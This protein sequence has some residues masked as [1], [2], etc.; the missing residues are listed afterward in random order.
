MPLVLFYF[1]GGLLRA[2]CPSPFGLRSAHSKLL[3][4]ILSPPSTSSIFCLPKKTEPK[5]GRLPTC[6]AASQCFSP[7][8]ALGNLRHTTPLR[9]SSLK[10]STRA[11][12]G[13]DKK[14]E[15]ISIYLIFLTH[16]LR[17][18]TAGWVG[19]GAAGNLRY[20]NLFKIC[21]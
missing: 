18:A 19:V 11:C 6:P 7:Q 16:Q 2:S 10:T 20:S 13:R 9:H 17:K 5:K 4:T 14:V 3:L 12:V 8:A 15:V 1:D 21:N